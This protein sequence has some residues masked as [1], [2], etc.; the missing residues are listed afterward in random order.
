MNAAWDGNIPHVPVLYQEIIHALRPHSPGRYV[1][2]TVGAGGHAF[3]ILQTSAPE[4][5]LLGLDLDPQALEIA[6]R[7]LSAF[8]SR[9]TLRQASYTTLLHQLAALGWDAV[10]GIVID[11]GVSSMQIDTPD[12]GFSFLMDGPLDMRFSPDQPTSAADLVNDL[13]EADLADLIYRYGEEKLSR[14]IARAIVHSR[15]LNTTAQLADLIVRAT[16]GKRGRIHP[17]TRTFQALRIAVNH[18]LQA[19]E[20]FLPQAVQALTPGGRLAVIS[21]HSLEDRI[22]K[23]YFRLESRDCICPPDQPICTC[24]HKASVTEI[25]RHPIEA[26]AEEAGQ[27]PRARSAKLRIIEKRSLA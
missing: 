1:D 24:G 14:R 19:L 16:G 3:G 2:A 8:E 4:G 15:P 10:D 13:P 7:R 9:A 5:L 6:S 11:L 26:S 27:N 17:A 18:E 21:F 12:R 20:E 22:V 23:Q 25:N